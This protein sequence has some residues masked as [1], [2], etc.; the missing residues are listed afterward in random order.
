MS[1]ITKTIRLSGQGR[2][3]HR[4]RCSDRARQGS[5][6]DCGHSDIRD[7]RGRRNRR[8]VGGAD[9]VFG[10]TRHHVRDQ[11]SSRARMTFPPPRS[12][13]DGIHLIPAP[14]PFKSPAWVNTYAVESAD[15][16]LLL[17]CGADWDPGR[18]A[19][20]DGFAAL[21]LDESAVHTLV[22]THLHPDHVGMS[23]RLV[24]EWGCRFVMHERA[25]TLVDGY[26]DTPGYAKR[27]IRIAKGHGVPKQVMDNAARIERASFMPLIDPPDHVVADGADIELGEG[28]ALHVIHTPGHEQSHICLRGLSYGHPVFGRPR[29]PA[30]LAGDHVG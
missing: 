3:Q 28:R 6:H 4:R 30:N 27:L 21:R 2:R 26:N 5:I 11:G 20:R 12:L 19:L 15:G 9:D 24:R 18:D 23:A 29:S 13:G 14:L 7:R 1:S 17:D 10:H 22:V 16:L 8:L 25:A